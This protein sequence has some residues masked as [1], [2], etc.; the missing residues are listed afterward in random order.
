[1]RLF[2]K[3]CAELHLQ[4]LKETGLPHPSLSHEDDGL[5]LEQPVPGDRP[6]RGLLHLLSVF[7]LRER[8]WDIA[9]EFP[10]DVLG[11]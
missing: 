6:G 2:G 1:M 7:L 8:R 5:L 9:A 10:P 11:G 4:V 3:L